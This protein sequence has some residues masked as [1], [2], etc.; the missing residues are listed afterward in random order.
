MMD[1]IVLVDKPQQYTSHDVAS[2]I[3]KILT[4]K[5]VG[6]FGT[7][8]PLATGLL[9]VAVGKATKFF[10]FFSKAEKVY[11]GRIRLGFSTDTYDSS[12]K[13]VS[14]EK[15]KYPKKENL[16]KS[17]KKY[18]GEFEQ[19]PPAYSAKKYRGRPLYALVRR[20][21]EFELKPI[22]V[23][24]RYFRLTDYSPPFLEFEV[25]CSS[26][27]YIRSLAHDLGQSLGCGAHLIELTRTAS[28]DFQLKESHTLEKIKELAEKGKFDEFLIPLERLLAE[29]PKIVL[30]ERGTAL[31]RNGNMV[32]LEN[33]SRTTDAD[34]AFSRPSQWTET[35]FRMFSPDE[36]LI[37]IAR[38]VPDKN[39]FQPFLVINPEVPSS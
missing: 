15:K 37:A 4:A 1:G 14:E 28:G 36:K 3:K 26:G 25:H 8:D 9:V 27:T 20:K 29:F 13:P 31:A 5:K 23:F 10:P 17:M 12:G 39:G 16:L 6:H 11:K 35:F 30:D 18:E 21:K 24:I 7:L 32:F 19:I 38:R 33:I 22:Q 2:A 34:R